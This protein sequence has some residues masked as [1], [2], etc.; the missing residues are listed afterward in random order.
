MVDSDQASLDSSQGSERS[1]RGRLDTST[2]SS[3]V[4][5]TDSETTCHA[6]TPD[7]SSASRSFTSLSSE[8]SLTEMEGSQSPSDLS[9]I[10][11]GSQTLGK[12][13]G[14]TTGGVISIDITTQSRC[15]TPKKRDG[16]TPPPPP[17]VSTINPLFDQVRHKP[18]GQD[19]EQRSLM[20]RPCSGTG[21]HAHPAP[22]TKP[23]TGAGTQDDTGADP[24][25]LVYKF[26]GVPKGY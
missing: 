15:D 23:G 25:K 22:S 5:A 3:T 21:A 2:A 19:F 16:N 18:E 4:G 10:S 14:K 7:K 9:S 6:E 26:D 13:Q 11:T 1:D 8:G 24:G 12:G 17:N 20:S